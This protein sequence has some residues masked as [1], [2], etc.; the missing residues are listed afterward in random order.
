MLSVPEAPGC[1][2]AKKKVFPRGGLYFF[3]HAVLY[4]P[5][6]EYENMKIAI[7]TDLH[8]ARTEN[9]AC[10]GRKGEK[11]K[12]LLS[13]A[14]ERLNSKLLPDLLLVGGDLVNDPNDLDLLQEL[15]GIFRLAK[16]PAVIIPGNHDPAP[17]IFYRIF[18]EVPD[19]LDIKGIR[20]LAF[21]R[22]KQTPGYNACR[23]KEDLRRL[24]EAGREKPTIL[25]QHV[26]LYRKGSINCYY[27]YDN[28]EEIFEACGNVVL[29][30]SGHE[31]AGFLPSFAPPFPSLIIPALCEGR[32]PFAVVELGEDGHLDSFHLEYLS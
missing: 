12:E 14:V 27:N 8:Y 31:H 25:F 29:S 23:S 13:L 3:H 1:F 17:E 15:S 30:I 11:A 24:A 18:P 32:H 6:R 5:K 21:P 10:P 4:K 2:Q 16:A 28:A 20:L 22:D 7:V 9:L 19:I 26:P